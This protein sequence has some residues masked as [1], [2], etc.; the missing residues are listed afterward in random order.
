MT[1]SQKTIL[2]IA[3]A[4]GVLLASR[5]F[6]T[7]APPPAS[8]PEAFTTVAPSVIPSPTSS[9][10]P[11]SVHSTATVP[12]QLPKLN[13]VTPDLEV[14]RKEVVEDPHTMPKSMMQFAIRMGERMEAV[15]SD[16]VKGKAFFAELDEC[17]KKSGSGSSVVIRAGCLA[18]AK[19]LSDRIPSLQSDYRALRKASPPS[20][21]KLA[22]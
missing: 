18:N 2:V 17:V 19:V 12:V 7:D 16:P 4:G 20:V 13:S 1:G 14:I 3:L 21:I 9:P 22:Q 8:A 6:S 10:S 5:L 15:G 11:V